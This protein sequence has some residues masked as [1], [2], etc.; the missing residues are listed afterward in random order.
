[1]QKELNEASA[2]GF[3]F[4]GVSVGESAGGG[5]EVVTILRRPRRDL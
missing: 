5:K 3:S 1:M 2:S 4:V